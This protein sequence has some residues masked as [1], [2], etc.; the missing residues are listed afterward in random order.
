MIKSLP[1][2]VRRMLVP[3]PETAKKVVQELKFGE[4]DFL[5]TVAGKLSQISGE[6]IKPVDFD[7]DKLPNY[8]RMNVR[9]VDGDGKTLAGG[10]DL[11]A[12][13]GEL[14][15]KAATA[16]A[17]AAEEQWKQQGLTDWTFGELP[18]KLSLNRGGV[19]IQAF[20]TLIDCGDSVSLK[21]ADSA[22]TAAHHIRAGL[23][24]LFFLANQRYLKEQVDWLP[25]WNQLK[26][27]AATLP[28][29]KEIRIQVAELVAD[30]AL[31]FRD[32]AVPRNEDAFRKLI[33]RGKQNVSLAVQDIAKLV[34]AIMTAYQ[35]AR[36][37]LERKYPNNW[38]YAVADM[39]EQLKHLMASGFLSSTP[40]YWLQQYPR[41][42]NAIP[43]RLKKLASGSLPRDQQGTQSLLPRWDNYV[44]HQRQLDLLESADA[45]LVQ[46]R[47]MLEEYRVSL[48]AQ[49][50]RTAIKISDTRLDKQ[51]EKVK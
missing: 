21:L 26:L 10:R 17:D 16:I 14:G 36:L 7:D 29:S 48:F 2:S 51:W 11:H 33:A 1:K 45:E 13:R 35:Q 34:P 6:I 41:Y 20:P 12:L 37:A 3:A 49:E 28:Y 44:H 31:F 27:N 32:T 50:L 43:F 18:A 22:S 38:G 40:W 47:W 24:R 25:N 9:V 4:G 46:Y 8:L 39:N 19:M 42:L 15:T 23:R 30:R 5:A